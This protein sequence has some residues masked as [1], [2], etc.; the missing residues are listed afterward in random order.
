MALDRFLKITFFE[1]Q[2]ERAAGLP[3]KTPTARKNPES[4]ALFVRW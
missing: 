3:Q 2:K 1:R 4:R